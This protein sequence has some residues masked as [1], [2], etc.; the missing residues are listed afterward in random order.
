MA[1]THTKIPAGFPVKPLRPQ[2]KAKDRTTCGHCGLA[3]DDGVSTG[4]TPSP[5][6]RCPFESF[7][8]YRRDQ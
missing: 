2:D 7:H 6:G 3:W 4:Y 5:S 8:I 1:R